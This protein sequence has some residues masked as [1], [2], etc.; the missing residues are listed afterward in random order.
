M[1][2]DLYPAQRQAVDELHNGSVLCGGVGSGKSRTSLAYYYKDQGGDLDHPEYIPLDDPPKDLYIITTAMKRDRKEWDLELAVFLMS[3]DLNANLYSNK[4]IIDSWNNVS[5]YI[6]VSDSWFIFDEQ[7]VVGHGTWVK[8]FLKITKKNQWI[9]LSAT[10]GDR[11]EDY[12][13]V[14]IANGFFKNRSEFLREHVVFNSFL[15]YP[16]IDRYLNTRRLDRLR[17]SILVDINIKRSTVPHH[18]EIFVE[19]DKLMYRTLMKD[20]W[21]VYDEKPVETA[22]ELCYLLRKLVNSDDSRMVKVLE[23]F[24]NHPKVIIFY[25]FD[26]ELDLLK[27]IFSIQN[28]DM[29]EWNGH[30][31]QPIPESDSWVYLVQYTAGAEG[32]N[33]ITTDTI[34]FFSQNYSYKVV[35]QACG[36]ID[37]LNT[38]F[39]DL[40]YYHLLSRS[41]IDLSIRRALNEKKKFNEGRYIKRFAQNTP[42]ITREKIPS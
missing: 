17:D 33:C 26:Y 1:A 35:A 16:K 28:C 19:Y 15:P 31:H 9:L 22:S 8:S 7:R 11:Y 34:I 36:R 2:I 10:P 32:W 38:P 13:P 39:T 24:E 21:N 40:Y 4:V 41:N 42:S 29:A 23:I 30:K 25:N 5:K 27:T 14:F 18:E 6:D 20:R 3:T 12:I 37:R